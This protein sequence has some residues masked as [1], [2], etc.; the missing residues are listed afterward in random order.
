[1]F[2][3]QYTPSNRGAR[4]YKTSVVT[5]AFSIIESII[6]DTPSHQSVIVAR[7]Q[8]TH[9]GTTK[10]HPPTDSRQ[11]INFVPEPL[12]SKSLPW[13]FLSFSCFCKLID[14]IVFH[15]LPTKLDIFSNPAKKIVKNLK[16]YL[17][18]F[19]IQILFVKKKMTTFATEKT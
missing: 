5:P 2:F 8:R 13:S 3:H 17:A 18:E 12:G 1:M 7:S 4:V 6:R 16:K 10:H 9:I 19:S 15:Y 11:S 14:V